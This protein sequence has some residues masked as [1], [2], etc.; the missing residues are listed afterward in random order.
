MIKPA[1]YVTR[2]PDQVDTCFFNL[3]LPAYTTKDT[4]KYNLNG[5]RFEYDE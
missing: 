5:G 4:L 1:N 2:N 3:E